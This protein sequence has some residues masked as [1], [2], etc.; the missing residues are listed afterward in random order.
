MKKEYE[1][2]TYIQEMILYLVIIVGSCSVFQQ[3]DV[4][5]HLMPPGSFVRVFSAKINSYCSFCPQFSVL[6]SDHGSY[7][8]V[9]ICCHPPRHVTSLREQDISQQLGNPCLPDLNTV[10]HR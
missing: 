10:C 6:Y 3:Y 5:F 8:A 1:Y 2:R 4:C 9:C 7:D